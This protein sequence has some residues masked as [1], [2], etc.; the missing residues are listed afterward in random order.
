[1][2]VG[3]R[4]DR[5]GL[6]LARPRAVRLPRR[7]QA[8]PPGHHGRRPPRRSGLHH[9]QPP[10]RHRDGPH[11]PEGAHAMTTLTSVPRDGRTSTRRARRGTASPWRSPLTVIG[12][13]AIAAWILVILFAPLIQTHD[14]LGQ[15]SDRLAAPGAGHWFGTDALGRDVFSRVVAGARI[16]I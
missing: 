15:T 1:A 14:P 13:A 3:R 10:G 16:S 5:A 12:L 2:A 6:R 9:D 8:R 11:R 7:H 4:P